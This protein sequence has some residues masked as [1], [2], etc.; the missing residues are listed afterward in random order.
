[1]KLHVKNKHSISQVDGN[2]SLVEITEEETFKKHSS[3]KS[4]CNFGKLLEI[5]ESKLKYV[6]K[7]KLYEEE[8]VTKKWTKYK[9][10]LT[11]Q[12]N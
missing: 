6:K 1:M 4:L 9:V 10:L 11:I 8:K 12:N 7:L 2:T 3:L 5:L